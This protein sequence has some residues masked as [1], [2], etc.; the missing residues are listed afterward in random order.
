[1]TNLEPMAVV[2]GIE[3]FAEVYE[4]GVCVWY[5]DDNFHWEFDVEYDPDFIN[6]HVIDE[7]GEP[8][9]A[10]NE[11]VKAA[12]KKMIDDYWDAVADRGPWED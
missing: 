6:F 2:D 8:V 10:T 11:Q 4:E 7:D 3:V 5:T 1:M 9:E 12:T